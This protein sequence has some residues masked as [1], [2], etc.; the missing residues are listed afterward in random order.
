MNRKKKKNIIE[1][2]KIIKKLYSK[3]T[4]IGIDKD[5]ILENCQSCAI[6]V[7]NEIECERKNLYIVEKLEEFCE[8]LYQISVCDDYEALYI[9]GQNLFNDI[10]DDI[11]RIDIT[12]KVVFMPYKASMWDALES[13]WKAFGEDK[14]FECSV[15][16]IPYYEADVEQK[17]WIP[18]YEGQLFE[19]DV[20]VIHY[21]TY[22]LEYE[23]PD[24]IFVHNPYDDCNCITSVHPN[25]YSANLKKYTDC[26]VYV[27]YYLNLGFISSNQRNLPSYNNMDYMIVQNERAKE[28]CKGDSYYNKILP[29]GSPKFD[30]IINCERSGFY[31]IPNDWKDILQGKKV[32]LLNTTIQE[33]L[34]YGNSVFEK[35]RLLFELVCRR[36][37]KL[38]LIWRPHPL[39]MATIM[40]MRVNLKE[41]YI[42]LVED[43]KN[44][45]IGL[46]DESADWINSVLISNGYIGSAGGSVILPYQVL[47][48]PVFKLTHGELIRDKGINK[49]EQAPYC[50]FYRNMPEQYYSTRE[51]LDYTMEM[52]IDD[53]IE[54]RL[55]CIKERQIAAIQDIN[56]SFDGKCGE[57]IYE[58]FR[59]K[60]LSE[61]T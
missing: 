27:P 48:K 55:D 36:K 56:A 44:C 22:N 28:N 20:E 10:F 54:G 29:F 23:K 3:L 9:C 21:D 16:P 26:L 50:F 60:L 61:E 2:L 1:K 12:Y 17:E 53:I 19:E 57:R 49:N 25:F 45:K 8:I 47:G 33:L 34:D 18:R 31:E 32:L 51:S 7:G 24:L 37:E 59:D 15:V 39:L 35:L 13:I 14:R 11:N 4:S 52:Y 41:D 58:F 46:I 6:V 42:K 30:K 43:F 40:S 5:I 38:I